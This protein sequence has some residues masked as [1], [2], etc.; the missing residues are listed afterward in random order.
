MKIRA[1][2]VTRAWLALDRKMEHKSPARGAT[3]AVLNGLR[4][5]KKVV[6]TLTQRM[7]SAVVAREI[8]IG[9][10]SED[11]LY[12][13]VCYP[14]VLIFYAGHVIV[15]EIKNTQAVGRAKEE[16]TQLYG[17]VVSKLLPGMPMRMLEITRQLDP[18]KRQ[19]LLDD[20][21]KV[22]EL[23]ADEV[24]CWPYSGRI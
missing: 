7:P 8:P 15:V 21:R 18:D 12:S 2:R 23:P 16:L 4:Y 20:P 1:G 9:F 11:L 13:R 24:G 5:E 17:P 10:T 19:L 22:L 3:P 6:S 14:D